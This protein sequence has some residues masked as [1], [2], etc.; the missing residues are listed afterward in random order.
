MSGTT[1][2]RPVVGFETLYEVSSDGKVASLRKSTLT[3]R[4]IMR[5]SVGT[6]GYLHL[7]LHAG[8]RPFHRKVHILV[9]EAFHGPRPVGM[10]ARH[11]DGNQTNNRARNLKWGTASQNNYD[12]VRHGT[13]PG[14]RKTHCKNDHPLTGSDVYI[15][16]TSGKRQCRTCQRNRQN[17]AYRKLAKA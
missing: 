12:R 8:G 10:Q 2:W 9:A 13:H 7:N 6:G 4:W 5:L 3:T 15:N 14:A 11:Q 16:P 17:N 1:T